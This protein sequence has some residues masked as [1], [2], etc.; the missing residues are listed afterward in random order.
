MTTVMAYFLKFLD[1]PISL[2]INCTKILEGKFIGKILTHLRTIRRRGILYNI[3][4]ERSVAYGLGNM[5]T[6]SD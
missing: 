2:T 4:Q 6:F 1:C 3:F 5:I